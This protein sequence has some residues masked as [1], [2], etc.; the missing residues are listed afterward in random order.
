MELLKKVED[1][2]SKKTIYP[3]QSEIFNAF[4]KTSYK[5][6]KVVILGQDPYHGVNQAEGLSFSVKVLN[7]Y[8][9]DTFGFNAILQK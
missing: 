4:R 9:F 2:Y 5:D 1:E 8:F 6:T 3:K 7:M